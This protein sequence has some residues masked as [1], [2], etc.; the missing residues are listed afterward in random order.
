MKTKS[1]CTQNDPTS[2]PSLTSR[3]RRAISLAS[4]S[5]FLVLAVGSAIAAPAIFGELARVSGRSPFPED[6]GAHSLDPTGGDIEAAT[7]QIDSEVE[8]HIAVD[9]TDP[10]TM[11]SAWIQDRHPDGGGGRSNV[12]G[13]SKDG[14]R[15]WKQ[16]VVPGISGC[17]G[18]RYARATDPWLDFGPDGV[19][20][21][22]SLSFEQTE[23]STILVSTSADG[24]ETWGTPGEVTG[25]EQNTSNDRQALTA[26]PTIPGRAYVAW[27]KRVPFH[28]EGANT[29]M[30]SSTSD[31]GKSWST[32]TPLFAAG[33]F[34]LPVGS[35]I[36]V[37]PD[38]TL[39]H[40]FSLM[41]LLDATLPEGAPRVPFR[42]MVQ[43]STDDGVSWSL[44]QVLGGGTRTIARDPDTR[45]VVI[46]WGS[47]PSAD[48]APDGTVYVSWGDLDSVER[49]IEVV[50]SRDGGNTW[51]DPTA[52]AT[53]PADLMLPALAVGHGGTVAITYYSFENDVPGD[54]ELTTD[55]WFVHSQDGGATWERSHLAGPF[56]MR[57]APL[58]G[59][60][61]VGD[62][63]GLDAIPGP[64][65]SDGHGLERFAAALSLAP[66]I[67]LEGQSDIFV[68][69]T[70]VS[71]KG[72]S[73]G[74]SPERSMHRA[75]E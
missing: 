16:V 41:N 3:G 43:R 44:P 21:L 70:T 22:A 19:A 50:S 12:V 36:L 20:Y 4:V 61:T 5:T 34:V 63:T 60:Y 26:H 6:C 53:S 75:S 74:G 27:V 33:A 18:G 68:V 47:M 23:P 57:Q 72:R 45:E 64:G 8:P 2:R 49:R 65:N 46:A 30:L 51:T 35:E 56:D 32:P 38:G 31:H 7:P 28:P 25:I 69:T 11:I 29:A 40:V 37:L 14:G 66:P 9:P 62:Y 39:L 67:A 73:G 10:D 58:N 42:I 59:G 1:S 54:S 24:G 48:V 15:S 71:R 17:T 52:A 13:V 55:V